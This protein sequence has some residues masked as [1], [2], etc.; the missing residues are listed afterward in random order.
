VNVGNDSVAYWGVADIEQAY[1]RLLDRGAE[2]RQFVKNVG[3]DIKV[4]TVKE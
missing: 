1:R 2:A 4:A 3:G